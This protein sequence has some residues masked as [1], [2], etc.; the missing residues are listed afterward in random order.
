MKLALAKMKVGK[1]FCSAIDLIY[2]KQSANIKMERHLSK[3]LIQKGVRQR[4]P[5]SP[6][7]FNLV[8]EVL[9]RIVRKSALVQGI[10][11]PYDFILKC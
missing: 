2:G 6:L 4:C 1:R 7:L 11:T 10:E 3:S 5:L 9:A 8:I